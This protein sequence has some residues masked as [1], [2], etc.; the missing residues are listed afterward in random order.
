MSTFWSCVNLSLPH[1]TSLETTLQSVGNQ[2]RLLKNV[3]LIF[4]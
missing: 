2:L 3:V 4:K 1:V